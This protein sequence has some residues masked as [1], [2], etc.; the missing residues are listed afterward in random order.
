MTIMS[1]FEWSLGAGRA[2]RQGRKAAVWVERLERRDVL[3]LQVNPITTVAGQYFSTIVATFN[4]GD[5]QG[6]LADYQATIYWTGAV[7]LVTQGS[8]APSGSNSYLIY[9][10]NAYARPGSDPVQVVLTGANGSTA[11]T[12]GTATVTDAPL[13]VYPSTVDTPVQTPFSGTVGLFTTANGFA[14]SSDFSASIDWGDGSSP[15]AGVVSSNGYGQF[16]VIGQHIYNVAGTIPITVTVTSPGGQ[17]TVIDS[18]AIATTTPVSVFPVLVTGNATEPLSGVTVATFLDPYTTDSAA[19]FRGII[20]WGDGT[21]SVGTVSSQGDGVYA[22]AGSHTYL[23]PGTYTTSIQVIRLANNQ[24]ASSSGSAQIGS[25][26]PSY[27]FTGGLAAVLN[28]GPDVS[29][30]EATTRQPAFGGTASA[31]AL[32]RLFAQPLHGQK[33]VVLGETVADPNGQWTLTAPRMKSGRYLVTAVVTPPAGYPS[34]LI[35][36]TQNGG[37]FLIGASSGRHRSAAMVRR[38]RAHG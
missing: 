9:S 27:A 18:T 31:F 37:V 35:P 11:Q 23:A 1:V 20:N 32:V 4:S 26:S 38:G 16:S 2:S 34:D 15:T 13:N 10:S 28:N 36:L 17:T 22:V 21:T 19:D 25:P 30:A 29:A 7:N 6:T 8:I 14:T 33:R 3:T 12:T 5:V 24:T